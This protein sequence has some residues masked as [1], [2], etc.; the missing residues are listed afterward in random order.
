MRVEL[1]C[2]YLANMVVSNAVVYTGWASCICVYG[3]SQSLFRRLKIL[4]RFEA[5][6]AREFAKYDV[7]LGVEY[8]TL[9]YCWTKQ[10]RPRTPE[11]AELITLVDSDNVQK[12]QLYYWAS[13]YQDCVRFRKLHR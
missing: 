8:S 10:Y 5:R 7:G 1:I 9:L 6:I 13:R 11:N 2:G 4:I 3:Y 12:Q